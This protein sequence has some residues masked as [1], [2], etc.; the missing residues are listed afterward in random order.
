MEYYE[1]RLRTF[2][3]YPPQMVPDK[4]ELAKAGFYYTGLSDRVICFRCDIKLK[5]W[6]KSDNAL[7]EHEKWSPDC[8][9]LKMVGVP[10]RSL[11]GQC[12]FRFKSKITPNMFVRQT[13]T[14]PSSS[15][16]DVCC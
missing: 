13:N 6:D 2:D 3:T 1:N 5:D 15:A 11:L 9:Y 12:G 16:E 10:K 4:Y 7:N 14:S 8:Q